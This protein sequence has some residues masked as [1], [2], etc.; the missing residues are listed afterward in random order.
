VDEHRHHEELIAGVSDQLALVLDGSG[1]GVYICLD[2]A[3]KACNAR[4]AAMLGYRSPAEW[5]AEPG[6]F[7]ALHFVASRA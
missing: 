2:D 3:H 5:A 4:F 6:P 7:L 1:Q